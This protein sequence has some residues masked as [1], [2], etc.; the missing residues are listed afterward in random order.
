[1]PQLT[2]TQKDLAVSIL[3]DLIRIDS[4]NPC[5]SKAIERRAEER[6][7][8]HV[9]ALCGGLGMRVALHEVWPGRCNLTAE[10]PDQRGAKRVAFEAHS[11][12]VDVGGMTTDPFAADVRDGK[13]WGRGACD[14]KGSLA[15]YLTALTIA[16]ERGRPFADTVCLI[17]TVGEE[18]G[19]EGAAALMEAGYR[20][21]A[22]VVGEPTRC[23]LVTAHKGALWFK[24]IAKGRPSHAAM[25][26]EG[27]NAI[28]A[29]GRAIRFVE[30]Q[31]TQDLAAHTHPLVDKPT[32]TV[33]MV[34]GGQAVNI[35]APRCEASIDCRFLPGQS[36]EDI[37]CDFER[38]LK[39]ALPDDADALELSDVRGH[40]AMEADPNG[41]LVRNLLSVCRE[42]TGQSGPKGVYYF[43]DSGPFAAAG[44][45]CVLFG[46]GDIANAHKSE[47][48]LDLEEYFL[49]V[50]TVL[51]WLDRHADRSMLS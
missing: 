2:D 28:Y 19:C 4:T 17:A 10:W 47:E 13:V 32:M 44:I 50:E 21:D 12:T 27:R 45:Q 42:M 29:M 14:A 5:R 51:N 34:S 37:T 20:V 23:E 18:T 7:I 16:R 38:K 11:D 3:R 9:S 49:A 31:Y 41:P 8:E 1:M 48:F 26:D 30:E 39:A 15:T 43:A 22:C 35:V 40:P 33:S 6:I 46:P 25:P 24:L 36:Y